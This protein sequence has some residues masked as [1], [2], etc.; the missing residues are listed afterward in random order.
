MSY[1]S[2]GRPSGNPLAINPGELRNHIVIAEPVYGNDAL[3]GKSVNPTN[4]TS[5]RS[6]SAAIYTAGG[7]ETSMAAQIVSTVSHVV[8]VRWS[9]IPIKAGFRV[10]YGSRYFTV[11]YVENVLERNRVLLLYCVEVNGGSA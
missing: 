2:V 3:G 4:W 5:V 11:Q 9:P 10:V 1:V 6:T 7:R 8:K